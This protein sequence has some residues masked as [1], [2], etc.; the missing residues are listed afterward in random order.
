MKETAQEIA[1]EIHQEIPQ[2]IQNR[3]NFQ[4]WNESMNPFAFNIEEL[5]KDL[6]KVGNYS[7]LKRLS[8]RLNLKLY[9]KEIHKSISASDNAKAGTACNLVDLVDIQIH[10]KYI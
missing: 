6:V 2:E 3:I 10:L 9:E 4:L 1:Q 5:T 8:K 7:L